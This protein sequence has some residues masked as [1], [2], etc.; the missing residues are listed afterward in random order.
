MRYRNPVTLSGVFGRDYV[1]TPRRLEQPARTPREFVRLSL[2]CRW[3]A[4]Y[5]A[6]SLQ[7]EGI[8]HLAKDDVPD[9]VKAHFRAGHHAWP[10]ATRRSPQQDEARYISTFGQLLRQHRCSGTWQWYIC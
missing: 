3:V 6:G 10:G 5:I 9:L 8:L 2:D 7:L 1:P 4:H